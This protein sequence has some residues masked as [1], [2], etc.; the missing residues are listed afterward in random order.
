MFFDIPFQNE[1]HPSM[2]SFCLGSMK[3]SEL[4]LR[5]LTVTGARKRRPE[6]K[7]SKL[8]IDFCS[9]SFSGELALFACSV[10]L[11]LVDHG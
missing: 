7:R 9:Q 8:C 3:N 10:F 1:A 6:N 4:V 5:G 11:Q 2:C